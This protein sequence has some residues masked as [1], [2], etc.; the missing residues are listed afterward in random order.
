MIV[1]AALLFIPVI[2][3]NRTRQ[4]I[5]S[6]TVFHALSSGRVSV[7]VSGD[8]LH[9]G[10]YEVPAKIMA[11]CVINMAEPVRPLTQLLIAS[12]DHALFNGAAVTLVEKPDGFYLLKLDEMTVTERIV[13]GI[14]LDISTM[15]QADFDRLPGIGPALAKSI[16]E[17]RQKNGGILRV[18]DLTMI[19][20]I[21]EKKCKMIQAYIQHR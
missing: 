17:Y 8:V 21:G 4:G 9:P 13:L 20:G 18:S 16:V 19:E 15:S 2:L 7:K 3:K 5:P 12:P 10:I 11:T 1:C 6:H 14:P